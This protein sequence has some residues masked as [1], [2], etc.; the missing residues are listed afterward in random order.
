MAGAQCQHLLPQVALRRVYATA[1]TT[2]RQQSRQLPFG[3]HV[4]PPSKSAMSLFAATHGHRPGPCRHGPLQAAPTRRRTRSSKQVS[5]GGVVRAES[6]DAS[7]SSRLRRQHLA[8]VHFA[9]SGTAR[10]L[11]TRAPALEDHSHGVNVRHS[12]NAICIESIQCAPDFGP[13][14]RAQLLPFAETTWTTMSRYTTATRPPSTPGPR[15]RVLSFAS[16]LPQASQPRARI[17]AFR[18][19]LHGRSCNAAGSH[20]IRPSSANS[21]TVATICGR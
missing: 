5:S 2:S 6:C 21:D 18:A 9:F 13:A 16:N 12:S 3:S 4:I 19:V 14:R 17:P 8:P 10:L 20:H 7:Q 11:Q 1:I 15:S